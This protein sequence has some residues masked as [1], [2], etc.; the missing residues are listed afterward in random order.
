[1]I[2]ALALEDARGHRLVLLTSDLCGMPKW[3]YDS[4]CEQLKESHNLERSQIRITNSHNHCAPAVRG[5]LEDY[6]PLD[7]LQRRLVYDYSDW[8]EQ[9]IVQ[10][11]REALGELKPVKLAASEGVCAFAVN[12]RNNVEA[13]VPGMFARGETPKGP[14]DHSVPVLSVRSPD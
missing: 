3:M 6:Y 4:I 12:R 10:T 2:K 13:E 14:V 11:I 7:D 9:Q 8:L 5:D 1:W